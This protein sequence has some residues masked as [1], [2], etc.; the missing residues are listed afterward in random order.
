M[1]SSEHAGPCLQERARKLN[2][3]AI[4]SV[5][6]ATLGSEPQKAEEAG[7]AMLLWDL[8]LEFPGSLTSLLHSMAALHSALPR[9]P[10]A[11]RTALANFLYVQGITGGCM[12]PVLLV[13]LGRTAAKQPPAE[14]QKLR[15]ALGLEGQLGAALLRWDRLDAQSALE[16]LNVEAGIERDFK[17][18]R[19]DAE[20][21]MASE[22]SS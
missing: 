16:G 3:C 22:V 14:A 11:H 21:N 18:T 15:Q 7:F 19:N 20:G 10:A 6:A 2:L 9:S 8:Q 1:G 13:S 4:S 17:R 5:I 12:L